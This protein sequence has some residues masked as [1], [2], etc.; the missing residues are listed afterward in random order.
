MVYLDDSQSYFDEEINE[1]ELREERR[2]T[3]R[4]VATGIAI[5]LSLLGLNQSF[6]RGR[7]EYAV[8]FLPSLAMFIYLL[9]KIHRSKK[10]QVNM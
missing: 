6:A 5:F 7:P 4:Y 9:W 2:R 3:G 1:E 10:D 8:L